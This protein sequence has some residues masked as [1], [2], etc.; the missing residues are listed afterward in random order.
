MNTEKKS[1][2]TLQIISEEKKLQEAVLQQRLLACAR[3]IPATVMPG[4]KLNLYNIPK[5]TRQEQPQ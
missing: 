2:R 1:V 3:F 4:K 5:V